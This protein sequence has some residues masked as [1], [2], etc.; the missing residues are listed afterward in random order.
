MSSK[1]K[2]DTP[3]PVARPV[4]NTPEV[5][6][7]SSPD[8][9]SKLGTKAPL[10]LLGALFV[11]GFI[12]YLDYLLL[13]KVFFFKDIGSDSY[14]Y[15]YPYLTFISEYIKNYG[16]PK[17]SFNN[18]MGQSLFPFFLRDPFDIFLYMGGKNAVLF[19]TAYKELAKILLSGLVFFYYLRTIRLADYTAIIGSMLF[20]FCGFMV[21]GGGW[22]F[23]SF[24]TFNLAL[25][26]LGFEQLFMKNKWYLFPVAIFLICISQPFNLYV[27]GLFLAIYAIFR[28]LQEGEF[29]GKKLG[30]LF[31]KMIGFGVLGMLISS[32][33]LIE[34][35]MQL[36]ES[37]RGSGT[38]SYTKVLF[39][40][41]MLATADKVQFGSA[42]MRLFSSDMIGSGTDFKGWQNYLEAP[43]FYCG[44][45]CLLLV[46]QVFSFLNK[47]RKIVFGIFLAL[48]I[49]P[50]IFPWFRYAFWLFSGDYYRGYS[51]VL[52]VVLMYYA[53]WALDHII[54]EKKINLIVLIATVVFL[55]IL[56]NY[57]YFAED[58]KNASVSVFVSLMLVVYAALLFFI[59]KANSNANMKY[60]LFFAVA[61][62]L[63]YLSRI[64]V[65]DRDPV[66]A[67]ELTEK[68]G[69]NDYTVEALARFKD[70][71]SFYRVDKMYASSPAMHYS[72]NDAQ[73]QGY[74]GTT[75]YNPFNQEHYVYYLQ[76]MGIS[77]KKDE[78]TARWATG[79]SSRPILE[80]EN[81]VKYMLAKDQVNP[82][83]YAICDTLGSVGNVKMFRNKFLLPFGYTYNT[84]IKESLF[85][86]ISN[87]QKDFVSLK[88]C[89]VKD[90]DVSKLAGFKEFNLR[91]T[92]PGSAFNF[93]IY[94]QDVNALSL[95]SMV[96]D[97][98]TDN[99]I[100]GKVTA[101]ENKVMYLSIPYDAGWQLKVDG[102]PQEKMVVFAGM[103]GVYLPKGSHTVELNYNLRYYGNG[104]ILGF[105]G[106]LAYVGLWLNDKR[107]KRRG[108]LPEKE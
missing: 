97:K 93:D 55:F 103:T 89:V 99:A 71:K 100:S 33:F 57:P 22:Y 42:V 83:W 75:E 54:R 9:F 47:R 88:A 95:D 87:L 90:A 30:I 102:K 23:F 65:N 58:I 26:L 10:L 41:P 21:V 37:P 105:I 66:T 27:Y 80:S 5:T 85:E 60:I 17:W 20:A 68:S 45:P 101:S 108:A 94:R 38:S 40:Q 73:A 67:A 72:L 70:D 79:L 63:M 52:A 96:V 3:K 98:F 19:G 64:S 46:P 7:P 29:D 34:N 6:T 18:G 104:L 48:W 32:P 24:E 84:Y 61:I 69:Y 76:L 36:L 39:S 28:H 16:I 13:Q 53:M 92:I 43:M 62:E 91:D 107:G 106:L 49:I 35:I 81:R 15:S 77:D 4:E 2:V 1:K 25:L 50:V 59:G 12:V 56:M 44:L 14:N 86:G 8:F 31:A 11:I 74:R 82:L 78:H 51:I